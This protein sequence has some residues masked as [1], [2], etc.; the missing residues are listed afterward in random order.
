MANTETGDGQTAGGRSSRSASKSRPPVDPGA[1]EGA[2]G[3]ST[4]TLKKSVTELQTQFLQVQQQLQAVTEALQ[5][6]ALPPAPPAPPS[7]VGQ[8]GDGEDGAR[9][10]AEPIPPPAEGLTVD[11][12][13]NSNPVPGTVS[14]QSHL[15]MI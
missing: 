8:T 4:E 5:Q 3:D 9:P 6:R 1:A 13:I 14:S 7:G 11:D 12:S 15:L 2:G 10:A